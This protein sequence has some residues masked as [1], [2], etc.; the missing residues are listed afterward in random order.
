[1]RIG[2]ARLVVKVGQI[3]IGLDPILMVRGARAKLECLQFFVSYSHALVI[4]YSLE[5]AS[6]LLE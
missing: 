1:M 5:D 4:V 2:S 6:S 3:L